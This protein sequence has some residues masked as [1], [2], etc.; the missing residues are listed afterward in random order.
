MA[1]S[2]KRSSSKRAAADLESGVATQ[3]AGLVKPGDHLVAALSGGVDSV[4]LLNILQR[5]SARLRIRLSAL[6]VNHQL[7]SNA[8]RWSAFCSRICRARG[9]LIR[10]VKV[11]VKGGAGLEAAARAARYE[12]FARQ[13]C[14]FVVLA[15]HQDD[16]VE[17]LLL[18]LLRGAGVKGLAA[19]PLLR[20]Q[21]S[22]FRIQGR[23]DR[24][25]KKTPNPVSRIPNPLI[26]RP[27]LEVTRAEIEA[28]AKAHDL[29]WV[30]DESN[31]EIHFQRNFLRHEVLPLIARRFPAYRTTMARAARHLAEADGVLAELA[32]V[33]GG[34][35][36]RDGRLDVAAVMRL[37]PA[38]ALNLMRHFLAVHG[39]RM[40]N[41]ARLAEALRQTLQ[42]KR[43][44]Q[45][46]ID[47]GAV[48]LRRFEGHLHVVPKLAAHAARG[49][50]HTRDRCRTSEIEAASD[51]VRRWR[52]ERRLELPELGGSLV[53]APCR[54]Q[55]VSLARLSGGPVTIRLR[56]G[57]ER[58]QP[59]ARRPRRTLKN[60]LQEARV[61]PW[62]RKRLPLVFC[63]QD[64]V[65]AP[66]IGVDCA[67]RAAPRERAICPE[68]RP[69]ARAG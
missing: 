59:D 47:L 57:G 66:A 53:M 25:P 2:R 21:D 60:L 15:H 26:L 23:K 52:G 69:R 18:Q 44:A 50:K 29:S 3:L 16:Q 31:A 39:V 37:P 45:V 20:I 55:G 24:E 28:Y 64:L 4:V 36:L 49:R 11:K 19:M 10:N 62:V 33:D 43:D 42:A 1:S 51:A 38:R 12:E 30:E 27:L 13:R 61:P 40:P 34:A 6:H 22:G 7:S 32:A 41:A 58:L 46:R 35:Q 14:D 17:T 8:V 67:Y 68:W 48:E 65:W 56:R 63:G 9:I 54:G 5:V